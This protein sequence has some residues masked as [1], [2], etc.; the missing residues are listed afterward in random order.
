M[1]FQNSSLQFPHNFHEFSHIHALSMFS[2]NLNQIQQLEQAQF[3]L[4]RVP[5]SFHMRYV[6]R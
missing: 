1:L 3:E 5:D 6:W 4:Y 2:T